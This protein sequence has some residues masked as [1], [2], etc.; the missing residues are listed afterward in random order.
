IKDNVLALL[1]DSLVR[2]GVLRP[3][4][5]TPADPNPDDKIQPDVL[6]GLIASVLE[7]GVFMLA[8]F[9]PDRKRDR[10]VPLFDYGF[11]HPAIPGLAETLDS[12]QHAF[13]ALL[14]TDNADLKQAD[15]AA[16]EPQGAPFRKRDLA[17]SLAPVVRTAQHGSGIWFAMDGRYIATKQ[18]SDT[19]KLT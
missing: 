2:A 5:G 12:A 9:V 11:D 4:G 8:A 19:T 17:V 1:H 10:V 13:V 7:L 15:Y 16:F 3:K 14:S 18:F 6:I